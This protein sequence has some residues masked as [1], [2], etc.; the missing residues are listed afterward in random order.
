MTHPDMPGG[1]GEFRVS[2]WKLNKDYS[3]DIQGRTTTDS[4]YD[5]AAGPK[6]PTWWPRRFR[7]RT[8]RTLESP[9]S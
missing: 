5:L 3:I 2:S 6:P 9:A 8:C 4:M 1:L 7:T